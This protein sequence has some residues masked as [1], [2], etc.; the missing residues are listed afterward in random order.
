M[1]IGGYWLF[2][3]YGLTVIVLVALLASIFVS[4]WKQ[5]VCAYFAAKLTYTTS[6]A[7][8]MRQSDPCQQDSL[9]AMRARRQQEER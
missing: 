1:S 4:T 2:V 7:E 3:L 6:L 8:V 5:A 9:S